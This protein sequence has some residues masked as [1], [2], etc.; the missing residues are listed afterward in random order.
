V[1]SCKNSLFSDTFILQNLSTE[2]TANQGATAVFENFS[3]LNNRA[4]YC[5]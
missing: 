1:P 5:L 4:D 2:G 3:H